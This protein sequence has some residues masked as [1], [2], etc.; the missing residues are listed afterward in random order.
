MFCSTGS[1]SEGEPDAFDP[2]ADPNEEDWVARYYEHVRSRDAGLVGPIKT[3]PKPRTSPSVPAGP[4]PALD[5]KASSHFKGI[6]RIRVRLS[7][8]L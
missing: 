5:T 1:S 2:P 4:M 3:I 6:V 7:P 8:Q